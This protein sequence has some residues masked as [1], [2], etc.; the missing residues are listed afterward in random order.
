MAV[1]SENN[2]WLSGNSSYRVLIKYDYKST[3]IYTPKDGL[4][5]AGSTSLHIDKLN[6]I[7]IGSR[8]GLCNFMNGKF[9]RFTEKNG[10]PSSTILSIYSDFEGNTWLGTYEDG[11]I[12]MPPLS[13]SYFNKNSG[14]NSELITGIL[15]DEKKNIIYLSTLNGLNIFDTKANTFEIAELGLK[16]NFMQSVKADKNGNIFLGGSKDLFSYNDGILKSIG[17]FEK[18][19]IVS[20][21]IDSKDNIWIG[22]TEDKTFKIKTNSKSAIDSTSKILD[23]QA[24]SFFEDKSGIVWIGTSSG[25][26][27][28]YANNTFTKITDSVYIKDH[29]LQSLH[30]DDDGKVW[31][32]TQGA[33]LITYKNNLF[34]Q[35]T[36]NDG[37]SSNECYLLVKCDKGFYWIGTD[38]GLNKFNGKKFIVYKTGDGLPTN[39]FMFNSFFKDP[40]GILWFGT[41]KGLVRFNTE[42]ENNNLTTPPIHI[43]KVTVINSEIDF[44]SLIELDHTENHISIDFTGISFNSP[45]KITYKYR[46]KNLD[47]NWTSSTSRQVKFSF[48]PPGEYKFEVYAINENGL[49]STTPASFNFLINPPFWN[50]I[51]FRIAAIIS[52]I[53]GGF[54]YYK[55][56]V[57]KI[58][59]RSISLEKIVNERTH[60]LRL[61]QSKSE[62]LIRNIIPEVLIA[63]LKETGH[64]QPKKYE[65]ATILFSDFQDFTITSNQLEPDTLLKEL[66]EIFENFD[67][68]VASHQIEKLKTIGDAYMIAGGIP[69]ELSDHAVKVVK[70]AME[71]Q[72]YLKERNKISH[73]KWNMRIGIN[74]GKVIAGIVGL[75]KFSYDVWGDTV[76]VASFMERECDPGKINIS[77]STYELVK[78]NFECIPHKNFNT[79]W[80]HDFTMYYINKEA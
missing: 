28:K 71:M 54:I 46:L 34:K 65:S 72:N 70:A 9:T 53:G 2:I 44:S 13:L 49:T 20:L 52:L 43:T 11:L 58:E 12:K 55:R 47:D 16:Q 15:G 27:L 4:V 39:H 51:G 73:V 60:E 8:D 10:I 80:N 35:F 56:S 63:E 32:A 25:V 7:W 24:N 19:N 5:D 31:I 78:N 61:E 67:R 17:K 37:L 62:N 38:K 21:F 76:N 41:N 3:T 26:L 79:K 22:T 75:N 29:P 48:I 64:V 68:I 6:T 69:I 59:R 18:G 74:S 30:V 14:L 36:T 40:G 57:K 66:N 1:D 45:E 50:S 23:L 33:G 42:F 77:A